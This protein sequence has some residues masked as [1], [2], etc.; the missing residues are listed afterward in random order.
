MLW[1]RFAIKHYSIRTEHSYVEWVRRFV[2]FHGRRHPRE[3]GSDEVWAFLGS[4]L[5]YLTAELKVAAS[6][7][8]QALSALLFLCRGVLD[9]DL[10]WQTELDR[11][12]K[13]KRGPLVP[14]RTE[15]VRLLM[16]MEG[17]HAL[18]ACLLYGTGMR[19]MGAW[20]GVA[21]GC[22]DGASIKNGLRRGRFAWWM[23]LP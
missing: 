16:V 5:G 11:P 20:C 12:K 2:A 6:T 4:L 3:M 9:V 23:P 21:A 13:P 8:P 1:K 18:M 15:V 17:T 7:H 19:L 14:S 10:P 22:G